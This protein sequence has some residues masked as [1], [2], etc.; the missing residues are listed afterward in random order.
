MGGGIYSPPISVLGRG[1][2]R[3]DM[4]RR[5]L[6]HKTCRDFTEEILKFKH[7]EIQ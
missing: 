5:A 4:G 7:E 6:R 3:R 1:R 2:S